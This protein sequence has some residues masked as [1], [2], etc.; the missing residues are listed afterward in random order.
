MAVLSFPDQVTCQMMISVQEAEF[1]LSRYCLRQEGITQIPQNMTSAK[2]ALLCSER[3]ECIAFSYHTSTRMCRLGSSVT[4]SLIDSIH[5]NAEE[6]IYI[7][8][9]V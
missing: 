1:T 7:S 2:C 5:C 8:G 9:N 3:S 4:D 6:L